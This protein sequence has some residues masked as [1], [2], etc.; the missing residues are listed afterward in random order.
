M[1]TSSN[2]MKVLEMWKHMESP[3]FLQVMLLLYS[4][5]KVLEMWKLIESQLFLQVMLLLQLYKSAGDVEAHGITTL[6]ASYVAIIV[7]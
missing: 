7:V 2:H 6:L 3:L 4:C 1:V 5:M